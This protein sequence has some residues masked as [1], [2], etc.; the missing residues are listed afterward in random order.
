[1]TPT[2]D[3]RSA[4]PQETVRLGEAIAAAV[5]PGDVL[6]LYGPLGAGKTQLVKGLAA[7]LG[8]SPDEPIV[9]PTFV[10]VRE[11][12]GR[13]RLYHLDAY[14]LSG[15]DELAG[16][17]WEEMLDDSHAVVVLEWADRVAAAIPPAAWR[18]DLEHAGPQE[19]AI[20]VTC[21]DAR[22]AT[23]LAR[24]LAPSGGP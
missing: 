12:A 8:V 11:Y 21:P 18:I 4:S 2:I 22:R 23:P 7:G 6:A 10:L 17:G 3:F 19:R 15:P 24:L 13:L 5:Q 14:R 1:M 20:R 16:L 9:S